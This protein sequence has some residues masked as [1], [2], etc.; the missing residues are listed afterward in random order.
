MHITTEECQASETCLIHYKTA[1]G[2]WVF[3]Y[4]FCLR[5]EDTKL[6]GNSRKESHS[7]VP[8]DMPGTAAARS[9]CGLWSHLSHLGLSTLNVEM[10]SFTN[11]SAR[12]QPFSATIKCPSTRNQ[13][14]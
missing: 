12:H 11:S 10:A 7:N 14:S 6:G 9:R 2:S 1:R 13:N 3:I 8:L 5:L 4:K